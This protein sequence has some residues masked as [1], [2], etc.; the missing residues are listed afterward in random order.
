MQLFKIIKYLVLHLFKIID[1]AKIHLFKIIASQIL[2]LFKFIDE[3]RPHFPM[4]PCVF[5]RRESFLFVSEHAFRPV[6]TV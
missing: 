3:K 4:Q 5:R 2:H 1:A 6:R